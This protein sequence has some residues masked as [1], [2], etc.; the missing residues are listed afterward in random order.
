[1]PLL[2]GERPI[3]LGVAF[4]SILRK[5]SPTRYEA[6]LN[7]GNGQ[8]VLSISP[9]LFL[10]VDRGIVE[11]ERIKGTRPRGASREEDV[12]LSQGLL[13]SEKDRAELA[14][15]VD[16]VRNDLG[17][18]CQTDLLRSPGTRL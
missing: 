13:T 12:A 2:A 7:I 17:R 16:V 15:I 18:V 6:F 11:S 1:M 8:S 9:E 3:R 10:K 4:V 5:I 14:M